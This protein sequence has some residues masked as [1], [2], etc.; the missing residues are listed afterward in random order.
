MEMLVLM[1]S[2]FIFLL[3]C[4]EYK[5]SMIHSLCGS[6]TQMQL[7]KYNLSAIVIQQGC[8]H[9][10]KFLYPVVKNEE[11]IGHNI[12]SPESRP[13]ERKHVVV[14]DYLLAVIETQP[15]M[16]PEDLRIRQQI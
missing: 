13:M 5:H 16:F 12:E 7:P 1:A 4:I 2:A 9:F 15:M 6:F 8:K 14:L 3:L 10:P 11:I